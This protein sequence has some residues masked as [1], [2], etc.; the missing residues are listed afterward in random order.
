M[1]K[2]VKKAT[3]NIVAVAISALI[4]TSCNIVRNDDNGDFWEGSDSYKGAFEMVKVKGGTFTMGCTDDECSDWELPTHKV[5][6]SDFYIG[7]YEVTQEEW[8]SVMGTNPSYFAGENLPVELVSWNMIVGRTGEVAYTVNGVTYR[9]DGFCYKL[10]Q[11]TGS[12]AKYRLP[13]EAE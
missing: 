1:R 4:M 13:T 3:E 11:K 8:E 12:G 2:F 7:K 9:T 5:T 6:L 10:S